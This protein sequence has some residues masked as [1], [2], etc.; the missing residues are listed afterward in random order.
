MTSSMESL[1]LGRRRGALPRA[2]AR[3]A[4]A[5]AWPLRVA[6]ARRIMLQ[7]G[8]LDEG[9]LRDIG[10]TRSDLQ[11]AGALPLGADPSPLLR[12]RREERRRR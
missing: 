8:R 11:D 12:R 4:H 6:E 7:L 9:E 5:L 2:L 1:R 3:V 10:L